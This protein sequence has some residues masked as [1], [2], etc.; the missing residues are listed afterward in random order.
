MG[1][2]SLEPWE[3]YLAKA[4]A[5]ISP[6]YRHAGPHTDDDIGLVDDQTIV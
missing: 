4:L 3:V 6:D 5:R 1:S 2:E